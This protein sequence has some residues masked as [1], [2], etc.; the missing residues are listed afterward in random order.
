[1]FITT[2][3]RCSFDIYLTDKGLWGNPEGTGSGSDEWTE[4]FFRLA[5]SYIYKRLVFDSTKQRQSNRLFFTYNPYLIIPS[6][7]HDDLSDLYGPPPEAV[8]Q[9]GGSAEMGVT[10]IKKALDVMVPYVTFMRRIH[11]D[12]MEHS[13]TTHLMFQKSVCYE[14]LFFYCLYTTSEDL[15]TAFLLGINDTYLGFA[16]ASMTKMRQKYTGKQYV[17]IIPRGLGKTRC[18]KLIIAV[19]LMTFKRCELLAMAHTRSLICTIKDDVENTMNAYF[20]QSEYNYTMYKHEDCM[21]IMFPDGTFNRLKYASACRPATLRG[22]DPDI[23]FLDEALCVSEDSYS[24]INAMIQRMHTK[25]GFLSSP[26]ASKKDALLNLVINMSL[27][28]SS[29]N[30]YRLSYFCLDPLHVQYSASHTGCYRKMFAPKYITYDQDNKKFEGVITR[31]ETSYEN[32][33]GVIRPE[34]IARGTGETDFNGDMEADRPVFTKTFIAHLCNPMTHVTLQTL[35]HEHSICYWIYMDPAYHPSVQSA[36]AISCVR[37]V[38]DQ[39]VLCYADRKLITH[40]DLGRV[41]SIMEEMYASCVS[42]LVQRNGGSKC[43]FFVAIERNSN[44]DAVRSYY[45]TWVDQKKK[46]KL[47]GLVYDRNCDFFCYVDV[48]SG[49]N[50]SY[51]YN[52]C[53]KKFIFSTIVNFFNT[54]HV[55]HFRIATTAEHGVYTK[56]TCTLEHIVQEIKNFRYKD[57]KYTGKISNSSTD[58]LTTCI[59][60][61]TF[62]GL[63][64]KASVATRIRNLKTEHITHCTAPW[65][66]TNCMCPL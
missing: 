35:P 14:V 31:T 59:V 29:I 11:E 56:D 1:M 19:A 61:S 27:R 55:T 28:C 17:S 21:I 38:N 33:L 24:V 10:R 6:D 23:G 66:S 20:P 46:T 41:S 26:I 12:V 60:M 50:L 32:E 8:P 40:G 62:L 16:M 18:I 48:Y 63:S 3:F 9:S 64:H 37:F 52:L 13:T 51:G 65:I 34:D 54:K 5:D 43:Y 7:N 44:P 15:L 36:I 53:K 39:V 57:R 45:K 47:K 30:L 42:T 58:D 49:R 2:P 22:N 25:I 4:L